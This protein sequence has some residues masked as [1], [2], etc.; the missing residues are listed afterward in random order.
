MIPRIT[1]ISRLFIVAI[2]SSLP[3]FAVF[4][5][6]TG[7]ATTGADAHPT[8]DSPFLRRGKAT[9]GASVAAATKLTQKDQ[10]F[11][12]QI[13]AGGVQAVEDS[14]V[15]ER[16]GG[17]GVKSIASRIVN[18]RGRSNQELLDLAKKKGLGLGTGKIK[19]RNMGKGNFD[20]QFIHTL[21]RD[22]EE[23]VRLLQTAASSSDDKDIKAW[24]AKTLPMVK[25][26]LGALKSAKGS[27][28]A[29]PKE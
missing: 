8:T 7:E 6:N 4:G 29:K 9:P 28:K 12:S 18:E 27:E 26:E 13:A 15:A 11:L 25:G 20:Q 5:Q 1:L 23:D 2:A 22:Y 19:A 16:E 14:K 10:K 21:S 17:P 3:V 24:A